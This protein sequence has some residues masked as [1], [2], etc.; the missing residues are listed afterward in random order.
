VQLS[1]DSLHDSLQLPSPSGPGQGSPACTLQAPALQV[2]APVQ[3]RLSVH[4]EPLGSFAVQ[5]SVASLQVSLQSPSPSAPGQGSRMHVARPAAAGV[6]AGAEETVRAPNV[7]ML[8]C[9]YQ[10]P[11]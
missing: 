8:A 4:A 10:S 2:S 1:V 5:L 11:R 7:G 3:K 6:G 9:S